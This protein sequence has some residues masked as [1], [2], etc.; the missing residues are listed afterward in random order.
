MHVIDFRCGHIGL[1][2][3]QSFRFH[4]ARPLISP[5]TLPALVTPHRRH[6]RPPIYLYVGRANCHRHTGTITPLCF[7]ANPTA[8]STRRPRASDSAMVARKRGRDEME[9]EEQAEEPSMLQ[10][11]RNMWQFANLAQYLFF[12]KGALRIDDDFGIEVRI[13]AACAHGCTNCGQGGLILIMAQ[14]LETECL[15]PQPSEKLASI[16]LALLK[17]VSSQKGLT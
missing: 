16:G 12:F 1:A 10:K 15:K 8:F 13:C 14:D 11:L 17:H 6:H 4:Q 2:P 3:D 9:S 5:G 7:R